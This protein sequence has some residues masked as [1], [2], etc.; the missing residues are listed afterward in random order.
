MFIEIPAKVIQGTADAVSP[1]NFWPYNNGGDDLYWSGGSN[2]KYYQ[3]TV[4]VS[5]TEQTHSSF[6]TRKPY[7]YN[8]NDVA[9]GNYIADST[10]GVAV[11]I[12]SVTS[13]TDTSVT[14]VVEDVLR[15][16][17]FRDTT[18]F[19]RGIFQV[20]SS[21]IIFELNEEGQP[22]FD[23]LPTG[24]PAAMVGNLMARFSNFEE[25]FNF[26]LTKANHGFALGDLIAADPA[27]NTF[28]LANASYPYL[29][30]TVT[31]VDLGTNDF[32]VN[33]FTKVVDGY[34]SLLGEVGSVLYADPVN[35]GDLTL[36]GQQPVMIKLRQETNTTV[37]GSMLAPGANTT[38]GN[39]FEV[40]GVLATVGNVGSPADMVAA[41]NGA[42]TTV[43][44]ALVE[45]NPS[46]STDATLLNSFSL[47]VVQVPGQVNLNGTLVHF[48]TTTSGS[49][50]LG[51]GYADQYDIATDI[52]AAAITGIVA[53]GT[54]SGVTVTNTNGGSIV[55]VNSGADGLGNLFAGPSS[56]SGLALSTSTG[57]TYLTLNNDGAGAINLLDVTGTPTLDFGLTSAENGIKAAAL[58]IE[59]GVRQAST[60]VV[61]SLAARDALT[62][63]VGDQSYVQN[64]GNG[65]WAFYIYDANN[66]WVKIADQDSSETDAQTAEVTLTP[67]SNASGVIH[68]I[69][70]GRRV[71]FVTVTVDAA[72]GNSAF[73]TIGDDGNPSRLMTADQSDLTVLGDYSATP[74]YTYQTGGQDTEIKYYLTA[75]GSVTG[76]AVVAI[77]YT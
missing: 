61:T 43:T 42:N 50:S 71:S 53:T 48:T 45:E 29:I 24:V 2:P 36:T 8:G 16:N 3:W 37:T 7:V 56:S 27:N 26:T 60:F 17:T 15:Y 68:T 19:G 23:P 75:N 64:V 1:L 28:V 33:P 30:G 9:V 62:V 44:A 72:F 11:K 10:T 39:T 55:F 13:K 31:N 77:T 57:A 20:N 76:N 21:I 65:E 59:Q 63:A 69:S 22:I 38:V 12:I 5:L 40:N 51:S 52:N 70:D 6:R 46:V 49:N 25:N 73:M 41:I 34:P 35:A 18:Q 32:M 74:S 58:I 66:A 67:M 47:V 14:C 54:S 4:V